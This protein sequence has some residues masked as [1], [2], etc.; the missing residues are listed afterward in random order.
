M[1]QESARFSGR[2]PA[3]RRCA[4]TAAAVVVATVCSGLLAGAGPAAAG[5]HTAAVRAAQGGTWGN[6]EEV[7]GT[8]T[9]NAGGWAEITSVSCRAAGDCSAGGFYSSNHEQAFVVDEVNGSWG[10]AE[11]VAAAL[12]TGGQA[13][14]YSLSCGSPGDCTAGGY[15][16]DGA[17]H[18]QA[19]VVGEINGTWGAP[20]TVAASLNHGFARILSVSCATAGN[21]SAGGEY[22][23]ASAG[24][25]QSFVVNETNGAWGTAKTVAGA[26][27]V[28]Q[29][30][31]L[32]SV[33]C[34]AP[35]ACSAG[36]TYT[37]ASGN[38]LAFVAG[39]TGG[40]WGAAQEVRGIPTLSGPFQQADVTS[41]SCGSVGN[42]SMGGGDANS[43]DHQQAFVVS[44]KTGAW[45][46]AK[47]V[48]GALSKGSVGLIESVSCAT[49]GNCT[50]VGQA[51]GDDHDQQGFAISQTGGSWG[52]AENIAGTEASGRLG[53]AIVYSVSCATAGNCTAVGQAG[54]RYLRRAFV[55]GSTD[56]IWGTAE[57]VPGL[58][59]LDHDRSDAAYAV[60]CATADNCSAG[61]EYKSGPPD[62]NQAFVVSETSG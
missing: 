61:G 37:D 53:L 42:C 26:L 29:E 39:E 10:T 43:A 36:G 50:A 52:T 7:P 44:E 28:G 12:N 47:K 58:A 25:Y 54:G 20:E 9:L 2:G 5:T 16:T 41:L 8:S 32:K 30:A 21:C 35:G 49:A 17:G 15:Y 11:T 6:A 24:H 38:V 31:E 51:I 34:A 45:G 22:E 19:F 1:T 57:H 56:G 33:S 40:R 14:I 4:V 13:R 60:S 55:V 27:N 3:R 23:E 62:V 48:A 18:V 46:T 59:T